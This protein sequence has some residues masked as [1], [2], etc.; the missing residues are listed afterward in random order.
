MKA[1]DLP[2]PQCVCGGLTSPHFREPLIT[3]NLIH[4]QDE[5]PKTEQLGT[6]SV[7][8]RGSRAGLGAS[9]APRAAPKAAPKAIVM[10]FPPC[11]SQTAGE[12]RNSQGV[13]A[14][15]LGKPSM[16]FPQKICT[17]QLLPCRVFGG[18]RFGTAGGFGTRQGSIPSCQ[19]VAQT[20][21]AVGGQGQEGRAP[22]AEETGLPGEREGPVLCVAGA[23]CLLSRCLLGEVR[24][25][26]RFRSS[27]P[28]PLKP[29]PLPLC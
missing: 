17:T 2:L 11:P 9:A 5:M 12:N 22:R 16:G 1:T 4:F 18:P 26:A 8:P 23:R 13:S 24:N 10:C 20:P 25:E 6:A 28:P 14:E 7:T 15:H 27:F 19:E 3:F 29:L 21:G